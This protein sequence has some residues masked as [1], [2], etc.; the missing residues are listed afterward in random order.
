[1][2]SSILLGQP[3]A[4]NSVCCVTYRY[5]YP[6]ITYILDCWC[7][8]NWVL[9]TMMHWINLLGSTWDCEWSLII[10][11]IESR[12]PLDFAYQT[13]TICVWRKT[14]LDFKID[15]HN[16]LCA[17][18][19]SSTNHVWGFLYGRPSNR[20]A[21]DC[22][23]WRLLWNDYHDLYHVANCSTSPW[24]RWTWTSWRHNRV[25]EGKP[26]SQLYHWIYV[27]SESFI[28][29]S[30]GTLPIWSF[31]TTRELYVHVGN[32]KTR[33][34]KLPCDPF[35]LTVST[36]ERAYRLFDF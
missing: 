17:G 2:F 34:S 36:L 35:F 31:A 22:R 14:R 5:R 4:I 18:S 32:R 6:R 13:G 11:D 24:S 20:S 12:I 16:N 33:A 10:R 19:S 28:S 8:G 15:Y 3:C 26:F 29:W 7:E 27:I 21:E 1:M 30:L 23:I 25:L 9:W